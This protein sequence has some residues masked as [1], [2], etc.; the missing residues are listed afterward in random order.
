MV[1]P[2][3]PDTPTPAASAGPD[4]EAAERAAKAVIARGIIVGPGATDLAR[5]YLAQKAE[6]ES[7]R[8]DYA[9]EVE[10][11]DAITA[12]ALRDR[13]AARR[14]LPREGEA[15]VAW[16]LRD[17]TGDFWHIFDTKAEA[18]DDAKRLAVS[19]EAAEVIAAPFTVVPL[20]ASPLP[21]PETGRADDFPGPLDGVWPEELRP[22]M[23]VIE[24]AQSYARSLPLAEQG[25]IT[26]AFTALKEWMRKARRALRSAALPAGRG[27]AVSEEMVREA[28][29]RAEREYEEDIRLN[30]S[31]IVSKDARTARILTAALGRGREGAV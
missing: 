1:N 13:L 14:S 27:R 26:D 9:R 21:A 6:L 31:T 29:Q 25:R 15:V 2:T 11:S 22:A 18:L 28:R 4:F 20:Y 3:N 30:G 7:L 10:R 5:A 12:V 8:S 19:T 23:L 16:G 24:E 17:C